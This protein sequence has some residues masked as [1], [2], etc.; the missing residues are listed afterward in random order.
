MNIGRT[1]HPDGEYFV[2]WKADLGPTVFE[3]QALPPFD[4]RLVPLRSLGLRV[5]QLNWIDHDEA[6]I[7]QDGASPYSGIS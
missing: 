3:V 1:K 2:R 7:V 4:L 5:V 6:V